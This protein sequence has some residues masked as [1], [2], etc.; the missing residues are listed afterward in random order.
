MQELEEK[1]DALKEV[2]DVLI[3]ELRHQGVIPE[4]EL[5]VFGARTER[6]FQRMEKDLWRFVNETDEAKYTRY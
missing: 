3:K 4:P 6:E 1:V 2:R 5:A